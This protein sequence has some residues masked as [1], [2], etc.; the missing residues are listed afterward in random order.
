MTALMYEIFYGFVF[1]F[2]ICAAALIATLARKG[3]PKTFDREMYWTCFAAS[4]LGAVLL[5]VAAQRINGSGAVSWWVPTLVGSVGLLLLGVS[6]GC[7]A[8]IFIFKSGTKTHASGNNAN[9]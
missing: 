5:I 7:F 4:G 2:M 3:V 9:N 1:A 8:G 6:T